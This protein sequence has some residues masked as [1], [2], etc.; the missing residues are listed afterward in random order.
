VATRVL[1]DAELEQLASWPPEVARSDLAAYFTLSLDDLRWA[2]SFRSPRAAAD[3]LGLAVQLS[4]LRF[5]GFVPADLTATPP[6]A[7]THLA[8]QIG[9]SPAAIGGYVREVSGRSRR[10]HVEAV[11]AQAGWRPCGRG[12]WKALGD[13]LVARALEHDTPSVLFRQALERLRAEHVVRPGLD[14]LTRAVAG[15]RVTA[16]EEVHRRLAPILT[17]ERCTQ[18][19]V[20]VATDADL[21][22]APLVWLGAGAT[23]A[24]PESVKTEATKLAYLRSLDLSV[25]PPERLRQLATLARRSTPSA[26]RQM[27][28][29]R[30]HPI[31]L[32]ALAAGHTEIVDEVVRLLD[33]ALASTDSRARFKVAE[34]QAE[35]V[36]A[37]IE[38]LVLLDD[39]L[40]VVLDDDLDDAA[41][42]SAVRGLGSERLAGAARSVV[43]PRP[44]LRSPGPRRP[45]LRRQRVAQRCR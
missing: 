6:E 17:P 13:W 16:G 39:I 18:L 41:V 20:L 23:T 42:G 45:Y 7:A 29:E 37:D 44:L 3:R 36:E 43:L 27:A 34:R 14:R 32:A 35:L 19:D 38:R 26:L 33:Q 28:P 15:A 10:E 31:L 8:K 30:R 5:L 40:E 1:S 21:G 24:S 22:V 11:I 12:E 9:V 2:R 4:A 25:I